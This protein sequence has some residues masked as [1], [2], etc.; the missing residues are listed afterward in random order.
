MLY[1]EGVIY[2]PGRPH[3]THPPVVVGAASRGG[4]G[5]RK[6]GVPRPELAHDVLVEPQVVVLVE[7]LQGLGEA[8]L[9]LVPGVFCL[10]VPTK[11]SK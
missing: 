8:L 9:K 2:P 3:P 4:L 7:L 1:N 6:F 11:A 10:V 5:R